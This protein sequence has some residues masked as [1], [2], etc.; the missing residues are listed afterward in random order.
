V[1]LSRRVL[2]DGLHLLG[3]DD[4][5]FSRPE[6]HEYLSCSVTELDPDT[7]DVLLDRI[8]GWPAGLS[9]AAMALRQGAPSAERLGE[10]SSDR[11]L[12]DY[13]REEVLAQLPPAHARLLLSTAIFDRFD[14][15]LCDAVLDGR[16]SATALRELAD[17]WGVVVA[18]GHPGWYRHHPLFE[19]LARQELLDA[20]GE[21]VTTLHRRAAEWCSANG[22]P[23]AAVEHAVAS[24]DMDLAADVVYRHL[25]DAIMRGHLASVDRWL[26]WFRPDEI[27]RRLRLSLAAGWLEVARGNLHDAERWIESC[28]SFPE[29][30]DLPD[31]TINTSVSRAAMEMLSSRGGV[32][33]TIE[34]AGIVLA[35]G[36]EGSPWWAMARL[37]FAVANMLAGRDDDPVATMDAVE[38]DVRGAGGTHSVA[39]AQLALLQLQAQDEAGHATARAAMDE[40]EQLELTDYALTNM[41]HCAAAYSAALRGAI[42][43]SRLADRQATR[44]IESMNVSMPRGILHQRLVLA[45]AACRRGEFAVAAAHLRAG[46][47]LLASEPAATV[48]HEWFARLDRRVRTV[49]DPDLGAGAAMGI[50]AA[51][52]R[53]L[54]MLPTHHSL[55]AIGGELYVSRNT[56]KSHTIAIYRKLGVSSRAAAVVRAKELGLLEA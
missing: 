26:S 24:G 46:S 42:E 18:E 50:T 30:P 52:L 38:F 35:A 7:V 3:A 39:Q 5:A 56:V 16:R 45:D 20:G 32:E 51:E 4:L 17:E 48:L 2:V 44:L 1:H 33:R 8:G 14:G 55:A 37:L 15:A 21:D 12:V 31:G 43:Q 9:L 25:F 6:A 19:Q 28:A 29:E 47:E 54:E 36:R 23:D 27:R 40:V 10:L 53:V 13:F 34:N 41:A 22:H 11:H 49:I